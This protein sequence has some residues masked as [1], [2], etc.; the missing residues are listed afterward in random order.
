MSARVAK[1][2]EGVPSE[3]QLR[4][5]RAYQHW[6][7]PVS[8]EKALVRAPKGEKLG[9]VVD[10]DKGHLKG[11][12]R[13]ALE[14]LSLGFWMLRQDSIPRKALQVF[15]G[16]EVHTLQ[17]RRPLFSTFDYLWKDVAAGGPL[18]QLGGK[19]VEE[20]LMSGMNQPL[21]LTDLRAKLHE[22]VSVSDASESGGGMVYS[23]KLTAQGIKESHALD[24]GL[25]TPL[26]VDASGGQYVT[27][28]HGVGGQ[29]SSGG[30]G[31]G[32]WLFGLFYQR[33]ADSSTEQITYAGPGQGN[34]ESRL[35]EVGAGQGSYAKYRTPT[36]SYRPRFCVIF[37]CGF[38]GLLLILV[39]LLLICEVQV[40]LGLKDKCGA[41][42]DTCE[43]QCGFLA[44]AMD[45]KPFCCAQ[46]PFQVASSGLQCE[47]PHSPPQ[48]H[49]V[50][51]RHYNTIYRKVPVNHYVKVQMPPQP[52][53]IHNVKVVT[54]PKEYDCEGMDGHPNPV[55]SGAHT[56]WCCY[57][58]KEYCPHTVV[59]KD[60]YHTV[61]KVQHVKVPVP[62]P[63]PTHPP[64]VHTIHHRYHVPSPPKYVKVHV[65]GPTVVK[66]VV[67]QDRVPVPVKEP[68][69]VINVKKPYTVHVPGRGALVKTVI[70]QAMGIPG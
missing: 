5:R 63:M 58:Y 52:P 43:Q 49:T 8:L 22:V 24:E 14:G 46:C 42:D 47:V 28:G 1:D 10:G 62:E 56:R 41:Y 55:W 4:L 27:V 7:V 6:G 69:Q 59:D 50:V 45:R 12:T 51:R 26:D 31:I 66:R 67:V 60:Y 25:E 35:V 32:S 65:P 18:V 36:Y 2:L 40:F 17:F 13:R 64:I 19:S 30:G 33:Y 38:F 29:V 37:C 44:Q 15:L 68:P 23:T 34:M 3:E 16:R 53:V 54:P 20:V 57:K 21:R 9:G 48:V 61:T 11:S 70:P 39:P